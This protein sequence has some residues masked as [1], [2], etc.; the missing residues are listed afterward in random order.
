MDVLTELLSMSNV[1]LCLAIVALVWAQRKSLELLFLNK[2]KKDLTKSQVWTELLMPIWPLV[3]GALLVLIPGLP[4]PAMF[5]VGV[6]SK[7]VLG[8]VLGLVSGKVYR[9]TKKNILDKI[10]KSDEDNETPVA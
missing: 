4:I 2:F 7:M 3:T 5:S 6:G 8:V 9:L 10:G 1:V